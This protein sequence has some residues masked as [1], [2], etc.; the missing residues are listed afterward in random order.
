MHDVLDELDHFGCVVLDE[1]F[2]LDPLG[3]FV[4]GHKNI[5]ETTLGFLE[6]SYLIQPPVGEWPSR[7]DTNKIVCWD[8][9]LPCKHLAAIAHSD[10]F[11]CVL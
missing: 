7:W 3:E 2:V 9:S 11:F 4:K 1:W 8:V 6:R 5:L 10:E